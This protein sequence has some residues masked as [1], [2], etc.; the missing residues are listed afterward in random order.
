MR[1]WY[2]LGYTNRTLTPDLRRTAPVVVR[3]LGRHLELQ[4]LAKRL[5]DDH[6]ER[7]S[8]AFIANPKST[9]THFTVPQPFNLTEARDQ[10]KLKMRRA[11]VQEALLA[12]AMKECT[13]RPKTNAGSNRELIERILE[14]ESTNSTTIQTHT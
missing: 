13:F 14:A 4:M 6:E 3:G 11:K 5:K 8:R 9:S 12:Q 7:A 1:R 10:A 2:I